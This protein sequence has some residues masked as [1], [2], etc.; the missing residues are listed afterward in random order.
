MLELF[1]GIGVVMACGN[2]VL[3]GKMTL[4]CNCFHAHALVEVL[5]W[6]TV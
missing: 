3:Q 2:E 5:T 4:E 1:P 6:P